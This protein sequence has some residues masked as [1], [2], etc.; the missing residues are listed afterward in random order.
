MANMEGEKGLSIAGSVGS[1][2]TKPAF[3]AARI[4]PSERLDL[5]ARWPR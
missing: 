4:V 5:P 1:V 3:Q 2:L